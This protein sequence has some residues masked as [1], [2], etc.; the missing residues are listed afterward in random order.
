M[1][2]RRF[3][4]LCLPIYPLVGALILSTGFSS[5]WYGKAWFWWSV[6][7]ATAFLI[8]FFAVVAVRSNRILDS[9]PSVTVFGFSYLAGFLVSGLATLAVVVWRGDIPGPFERR[10]TP[11]GDFWREP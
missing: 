1:S 7:Q 4:L 9:A 6:A 8:L 5:R 10:K 2:A 3:M 11:L